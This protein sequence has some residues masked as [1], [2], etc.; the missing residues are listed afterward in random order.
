MSL[1]HT[2]AIRSIATGAALGIAVSLFA[3]SSAFA[4]AQGRGGPGPGADSGNCTAAPCPPP[5]R[6]MSERDCSCTVYKMRTASGIVYVKDCYYEDG[7]RV[8]YCQPS[9]D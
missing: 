8:R 2:H 5:R 9:N 1:V 3:G 7:G 6:R 4:Q